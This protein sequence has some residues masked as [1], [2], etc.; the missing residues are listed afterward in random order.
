LLKVRLTRNQFHA[1]APRSGFG[2]SSPRGPAKVPSPSARV[3][4]EAE[5]AAAIVGGPVRCPSRIDLVAD[6][7]AGLDRPLLAATAILPLLKPSKARSCRKIA[8]IWR[9]SDRFELAKDQN[10]WL[11]QGRRG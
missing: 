7:R 9:M 4:A 10:S 1:V 6:E 5:L 3:F 11:Q 2:A 8:G